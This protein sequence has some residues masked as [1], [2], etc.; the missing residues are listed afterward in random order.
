[1]T[2]S[3]PHKIQNAHKFFGTLKFSMSILDIAK[4]NILGIIRFCWGLTKRE[5]IEVYAHLQNTNDEIIQL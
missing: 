1:M 4:W 5:T 2:P 3:L